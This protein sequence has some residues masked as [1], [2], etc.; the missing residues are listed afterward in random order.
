MKHVKIYALLFLSPG[1]IA[2]TYA[3][4]DS[5]KQKIVED[6]Q[7]AK[8]EFIKTDSKMSDLFA[9]ALGYAIFPNVGKG[10]IGVGGAAGNGV[11]YEH[12]TLI[13]TAKL[14]QVSVGLQL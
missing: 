11:V 4:S 2:S 3:Q 7:H 10:G 12:D 13:G 6:S 14:T 8:A 9:K 5:K 1:L